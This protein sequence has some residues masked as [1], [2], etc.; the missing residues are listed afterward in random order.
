MKF[1]TPLLGIL[2]SVYTFAHGQGEYEPFCREFKYIRYQLYED[3]VHKEAPSSFVFNYNDKADI[4]VKHPNGRKE[5]YRKI[6]EIE[7]VEY[8]GRSAQHMT[9]L[10]EEDVLIGIYLFEDGDLYVDLLP[11]TP[12][13]SYIHF[14]NR[15][16]DNFFD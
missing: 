6:S 5:I 2:F 10:N 9:V 13:T 15:T 1:F 11:E 12:Y 14:T 4:K 3:V 8:Q 16:A 7:K